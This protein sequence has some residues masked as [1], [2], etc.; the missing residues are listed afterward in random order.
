MG[1]EKR[2]PTAAEAVVEHVRSWNA[3]DREAWLAIFAEQV[4]M[5]DPVGAPPK[6]G[7]SALGTTWERSHRP[8]RSW[9]LEPRRVV[10][11]DTEVAVD[12]VNRGSIDGCDV[13]IESIEVWRVDGSGLVVSVRSFFE[14]DPEVN[15]P[16]YLRER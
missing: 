16:W 15:D 5:E 11:S 7:R 4:V 2:S 6:V 14:P 12:L 8:G 9:R 10:G 1:N 13:V 3:G